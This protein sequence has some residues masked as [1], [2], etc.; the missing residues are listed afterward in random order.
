MVVRGV[1]CYLRYWGQVRWL[2][3]PDVQHYVMH[4]GLDRQADLAARER[5]PC[6]DIRAGDRRVLADLI[7]TGRELET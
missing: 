7:A 6:A 5:L 3:V 1:P 4:E 2:A